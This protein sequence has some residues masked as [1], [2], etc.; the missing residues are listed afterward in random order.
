MQFFLNGI[1]WG[2]WMLIL[3]VGTGIYISI[4][5]GFIQFK[6]FGYAMKN[7]LGKIFTKSDAGE[8]EIT[9]FQAITTALAATV[10][11]GNITG[12]TGA[13][14]VGGPGAVFWMWV[15]AILGMA[16]KYSE[17]ALAVKYRERNKKGEWVGGPMYYI[18]NGLG[19]HLQFLAVLFCFLGAFAAIGTGCMT[20]INTIASSINTTIASFGVN[21]P[22]FIMLD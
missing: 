5:L 8:G 19:S 10:R 15:S 9:P 21:I 13:I 12:V 20:Q 6:K 16:T 7:T 14:A 11:T 2:P 17:I 22:T 18:K 3:L 4:K 1:A